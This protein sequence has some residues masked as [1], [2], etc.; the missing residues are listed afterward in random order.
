MKQQ[1]HLA[2]GTSLPVD[3]V[4]ES[5]AI[6]AIKR[7]GKS[8]TARR[9]VEQ[10]YGA[11]QQCVVVDPKG[12]WWGLLYGKNGQSP[13][14]PFVVL[15]GEHG[16][17]PLTGDLQKTGE[18]VARLAAIERAN[19]VIDL[20]SFRKHEV[21]KFMTFF[22]EALYRLKAKDEYRT[23]MMLVI[24]EADVVAPQRPIRTE[25]NLEARMLGAAEDIVRRGG[26]RGIGITMA[27]QRAA[28]LNK[29]V[30]SQMGMLVL[31]RTIAPQDLAALDAWVENHG[32]AEQRETCMSSLPSLPTGTAWLWSPSFPAPNGIFKRVAVELPETFDSSQTPKVGGKPIVPKNAADVDLK[33]FER[34]MAATIE[35]AKAEDPKELHRRIREL[36][37]QLKQGGGETTKELRVM[38]GLEKDWETTFKRMATELKQKD[39]QLEKAAVMLAGLQKHAV[40]MKDVFSQIAKMAGEAGTGKHK[41]EL[42]VADAEAVL[43]ELTAGSVKPVHRPAAERPPRTGPHQVFPKPLSANAPA[44][45]NGVDS[46][47]LGKGELQ[48][49]RAIAQHADQGVSREQLTVLTGYKR[50]S[51]DT[52]LQRLGARGLVTFSGGRILA[53]ATGVTELGPGFEPL[54]QGEALREH[55][56]RR[57]SGGEREILSLLMQIYPAKYSRDDI[58]HAI[59]YKRSSRDTY[60]QRLQARR[61]IDVDRDGIKASDVLF[62]EV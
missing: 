32:T 18:L 52:Y 36:E 61:L 41:F 44:K 17:V 6:L 16:H 13:G 28:V 15:G 48:I 26:Q 10:L 19:M 27:T 5:I 58:S 2:E 55:W 40:M 20:S 59:G 57:L 4:T 1:I 29:N 7:A 23:P 35:K 38:Q 30:L 39:E 56:M 33:A 49:L 34:E 25:G 22:L 62:E 24:D 11:G 3:I 42:P 47:A 31:L 14:L 45:P 37:A 60:I 43:K 46:S 53:T 12:D 54:P 9:L 50:S 51:R 21:T 8:T